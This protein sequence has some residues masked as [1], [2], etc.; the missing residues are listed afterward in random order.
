MHIRRST[1]ENHVTINPYSLSGE[2]RDRFIQNLYK[3]HCQIFDGVSKETLGEYILRHRA[4]RTRIRI[5]RNDQG[6]YIGYHGIHLFENKVPG[7]SIVAVFRAEAG[8]LP[9]FRGKHSTLCLSYYEFVRYKL[10]HPFRKT[11]Y[12]GM[13]VHP[14]SYHLLAMY[15]PEIY[16][17]IN[18][19]TTKETTELMRLLAGFFKET[20]VIQEN[21]FIL[22]VGW[23]VH[24]TEEEKSYW[25][26]C[27]KED[28]R[29]FLRINPNYHDG[30]G[31][32]TLAPLTV[33]NLILS[34]LLH[35]KWIK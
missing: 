17:N 7:G 5:F 6:D 20:K 32:L 35:K 9:E 16:P 27:Q 28:V 11:Y 18:Q 23:K 30:H 2:E 25:L 10:L 13:L 15:C 26:N 21:P 1:S 8:L 33:K 31:L 24:E 3:L 19:T 14:S 34:Y 4:V 22:D 12:L 29:F